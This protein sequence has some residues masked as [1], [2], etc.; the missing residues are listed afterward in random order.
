MN[1]L[2]PDCKLLLLSGK[3]SSAHYE[4]AVT[5][6]APYVPPYAE[7]NLLKSLELRIRRVSER[8]NPGTL[9]LDL[10]E[11]TEHADDEYF[12]VMAKYFHDRR[13]YRCVF[14]VRAK[15][16]E[17]LP[18]YTVLRTYLPV[19]L[20]E[21]RTFDDLSALTGYIKEH[22]KVTPRAAGYLAGLVMRSEGEPLRSYT[23][24]DTLIDE[25]TRGGT[26]TVGCGE[27]IRS[28]GDSD[29]LLGV[30]FQNV[31][32]VPGGEGYDYERAI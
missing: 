24:L 30:L 25:L 11:W 18:L 31:N 4:D 13:A 7:F 23:A 6:K 32:D 1:K 29:S 9:V 16:D 3:D 26:K 12:E 10:T 14:I 20:E 2:Y 15:R 22:E 28:L 8:K 21:D 27:L 19:R 5:M 17:A